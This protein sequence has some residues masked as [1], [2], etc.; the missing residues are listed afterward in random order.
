MGFVPIS[1]DNYNKKHLESSQTEN[2]NDMRKKLNAA[3][4]E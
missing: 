2:K 3:I 1:I 4:T